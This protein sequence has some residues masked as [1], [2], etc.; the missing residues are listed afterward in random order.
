MTRAAGGPGPET[1]PTD[2]GRGRPPDRN[3][4][5]RSRL[6]S[7]SSHPSSRPARMT[8]RQSGGRRLGWTGGSMRRHLWTTGVATVSRVVLAGG[9]RRRRGPRR[10][11]R[12]APAAGAD[13]APVGRAARRRRRLDLQRRRG[14]RGL[15]QGGR[16]RRGLPVRAGLPADRGDDRRGGAGPRAGPVRRLPHGARRPRHGRGPGDAARR[17]RRPDPLAR[18]GRRRLRGVQPR[19]AAG[20]HP[21]RLGA[22]GAVRPARRDRARQRPALPGGRGARPGRGGHGRA[23]PA[24]PR[25]ARHG[26]PGPRLGDRAPRRGRPGSR[27][28]PARSTGPGSPR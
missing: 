21:H 9:R 15:P 19:P 3:G 25:G 10:R 11:V 20:V 23:G 2:P 18:R 7:A 17:G 12:A 28:D 14:R 24:G 13:P 22:A 4:S 5:H 6:S 27:P 26:R 16:H 1:A 8:L